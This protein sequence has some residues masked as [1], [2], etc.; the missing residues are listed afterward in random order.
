MTCE[1]LKIRKS[2]EILFYK[3]RKLKIVFLRLIEIEFQM[4]FKG[5]LRLIG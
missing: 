4:S 1:Y 5:V 2:I 3:N